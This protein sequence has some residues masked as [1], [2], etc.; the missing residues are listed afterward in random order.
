MNKVILVGRVTSII[1]L[2]YTKS[3]I[4]Y[5][6]F[7]LAIDRRRYNLDS[8]P[9]TDYIPV[10]AWRQSAIGLEKLVTKGSL[11]LV[12]GSLNTNRFQNNEGITVNSFEISLEQFEILE[13]KE[14]FEKRKQ[15]LGIATNNMQ[16]TFVEAPIVN[17]QNTYKKENQTSEQLDDDDILADWDLGE[18]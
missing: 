4:A 5:T 1:Q 6:R 8:E 7:S 3:N 16:P 17:N 2:N 15:N 9:I 13:T 14:Q 10:V 12:E 18:I 11:L